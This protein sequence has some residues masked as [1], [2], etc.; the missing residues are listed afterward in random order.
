MIGMKKLVKTFLLFSLFC[1]PAKGDEYTAYQAGVEDT[2]YY[3]VNYVNYVPQTGYWL[4][5]DVSEFSLPQI[6][7][8]MKLG[9]QKSGQKPA[10]LFGNGR[11]YIVF[12]TFKRYGDALHLKKVLES[13]GVYGLRIKK[14]NR[15]ERKNFKPRLVK[16]LYLCKYEEYRG[17]EGLKKLLYKMIEVAKGIDDPTFDKNAFLEDA[18]IMLSKLEDYK[19]KRESLST[20][21]IEPLFEEA[22]K[23]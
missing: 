8:L 6:I 7:L 9:E 22:L 10:Y 19:K 5:L 2:V 4:M 23:W 20:K 12:A 16:N 17:V 11:D 3:L 18:R 1:I 21:E 15:D 14:V 13:Y